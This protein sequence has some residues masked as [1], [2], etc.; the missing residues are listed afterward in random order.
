MTSKPPPD[1]RFRWQNRLRSFVY[2]GRGL[3]W[4]FKTQHNAWLHLVAAVGAIGAGFY[5]GLSAVEWA[6]VAGVIGA[7][8]AAE[9]FNTALELLV[10]FISPEYHPLAGRIKDVAAGAV[11]L[12]AGAAVVVGVLVFGPKLMAWLA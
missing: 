6:L 11:L 2:A 9:A 12:T 7:V 4:L 10:D 1:P 8:L 3:A 5:F